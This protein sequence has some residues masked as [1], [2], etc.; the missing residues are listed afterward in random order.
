MNKARAVIIGSAAILL[1]GVSVGEDIARRLV[2]KRYRQMVEAR[3][4]LEL[5]VGEMVATHE[6]LKNELGDSQR[7][8]QELTDALAQAREQLENAVGHLAQETKTGRELSQRLTSV[9]RQMEQ[10]QGELAV[11]LQGRPAAKQSDSASAAVQLERVVVSDADAAALKGRI[12]SIHKDWNFV[13]IDLGWDA[14]RIGDTVS[15]VR[16]GE[17]LA[18]ARI[19]RVQEDVCAATLVSESESADVRINDLVRVL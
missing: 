11:A 17:I 3:R 4:Q 6:Q 10:M 7:R 13:V 9:Q 2:T 19:D 8:S 5:Q 12:V 14:V 18:K 15:I 1:A 16:N